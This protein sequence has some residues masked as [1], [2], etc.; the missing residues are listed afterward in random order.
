MLPPAKLVTIAGGTKLNG[1]VEVSA[2]KNSMLRLMVATILTADPCTLRPYPAQMLDATVLLGMLKKLG[3]SVSIE[4]GIATIAEPSGFGDELVWTDRSIRSTILMAAA[5][6]AR[7]GKASV[8]HPGGCAIGSSNDGERKI[9]LHLMIFEKMG[10]RWEER[11]DALYVES[12]GGRLQGAD[13]HLP[14]RSTGATESGILAGTLAQGTTTIW[15]PHMRPEILDLIDMLRSMGAQIEV[16]GQERVV[17]HGVDK[18]S[19]TNH[20]CVPDNV[21]ALTWAVAAAVTGGDV[22]IRNFPMHHLEVPL[23][24]LKEAGIKMYAQGDTVIVRNS[25]CQPID[26][27]TGPY[28]G[29]NSDMQPIFA[30]LG[31]F[32]RGESRIVDL[33]FQGR[34]QYAQEL[35][36]MGGKTQVDG[37]MLRIFG[38]HPLHGAEVRATDLRAGIAL[39]IAG[40]A[41][42]G[43][44]VISD[45]W[46]VERG[47]DAVWEKLTALGATI[48]VTR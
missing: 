34:Y 8:P 6:L 14:I 31:V 19:G 1:T 42:S 29:I 28:P 21:E 41:A 27:S 36:R 38:G 9:D 35:E 11:G 10:A 5:M 17:I 23:I 7:L 4:D 45:A 16:H 12:P 22:E 26:I 15:G 43:R 47:Y 2:A 33:R 37:N 13:I 48:E 20:V 30:A 39:L 24:F 3:K 25:R 46:Q 18:L 44:T 32:A 40:L